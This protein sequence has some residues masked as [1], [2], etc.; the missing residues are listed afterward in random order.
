MHALLPEHHDTGGEMRCPFCNLSRSKSQWSQGQWTSRS[1]YSNGYIGCRSCRQACSSGAYLSAWPVPLYNFAA[2]LATCLDEIARKVARH[3]ATT[4]LWDRFMASWEDDVLRRTRKE[5]SHYGALPSTYPWEPKDWMEVVRG[6]GP[7]AHTTARH[8]YDAPSDVYACSIA[9]LFPGAT[10]TGQ[11]NSEYFG[12]VVEAILG[13]CWFFKQRVAITTLLARVSKYIYGLKALLDIGSLDEDLNRSIL[14]DFIA[15]HSLF[16]EAQLDDEVD[17]DAL[18]T[19]QFLVPPSFLDER[20]REY[21][22]SLMQNLSTAV[23]E[24]T[25]ICNEPCGGVG[26]DDTEIFFGG[27]G[28]DLGDNAR[29]SSSS[30]AAD[31]AGQHGDVRGDDATDSAPRGMNDDARQHGD[32]HFLFTTQDSWRFEKTLGYESAAEADAW[33]WAAVQT[34]ASDFTWGQS[35]RWEYWVAHAAWAKDLVVTHI[36]IAFSGTPRQPHLWCRAGRGDAPVHLE[37][38]QAGEKTIVYP[39]SERTF[40]ERCGRLLASTGASYCRQG[41][42]GST[43]T[44]RRRRC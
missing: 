18:C 36:G 1:Q 38:Y 8:F 11:H 27:P 31:D 9:L 6:V 44:K 24:L 20:E 43:L 21:I 22:Q 17:G 7:D 13:M 41:V 4:Y 35:V 5:M 14:E 25:S 15:D 3:P 33:S 28:G 37:L 32:S 2:G 12:E 19:P 16:Y 34:E 40:N 26:D 42:S 30:D 29:E 39:I 23:P 10:S